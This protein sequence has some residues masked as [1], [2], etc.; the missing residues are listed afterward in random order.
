MSSPRHHSGWLRLGSVRHFA[1]YEL[2]PTRG[3]NWKDE[4]T[5][6]VST[7]KRKLVLKTPDWSAI[8][9]A[10]PHAKTFPMDGEL[11][12]AV[13][14]GV[15]ETIVLR[16]MGYDDAPA[17]IMS[18]YNW[19]ARFKPMDLQKATAAFLTVYKR[20]LV[21]NEP[22]TGKSISSLWAADFLLQE[23]VVKKVL[24]ACPLSTTQVVWG[25]EIRHHLSHRSFEVLTGSKEQRLKRLATPGLQYAV[26][27]HD[28]FNIMK[29]HLDEFDLVI[30]DEATAL[31]TPG[32]Q[33]FRQFYQ[34]VQKNDVWLW[35]LTGT[36]ISQSPVDAWT[37]ARLVQNPNVPKSYTAFRDLV[38]DKITTFKYVPRPNAIQVCKQVLQPSIRFALDEFKELP[39]SVFLEHECPMTPEQIKLFR[40]M[41]ERA[42][43]MA[44]DVAAPNMA[45]VL[46]KLIQICCGVVYATDG[47]RIDID[48]TGRYEVLKEICNELGAH[49]VLSDGQTEGKVIVFV[50][51]RGVQDRL[52]EMM[53]KDGY[54]VVSVHGDVS[55]GERNKIFDAFQNSRQ[56][57]ILLAH[58]KVAAHGLTLTRAKDIIWY[59]PIYSLESYEQANA[60]IRRL[61]TDG[62]TRIHHLFGTSFEKEL[63]RRLQQKKR[64]LAE[65]LELVNGT[66][67]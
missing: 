31:K 58:P 26:I 41:K 64:V 60:R 45:V 35:L 16:N 50:P 49:D 59:A 9:A 14:H 46:M 25:K 20:A 4:K 22:G 42:V 51:L 28:G 23:G 6:L 21:L 61:T 39:Q 15:E 10:I 47:D 44:H 5:M 52:Q 33:R 63:Y 54:D 48:A 2:P 37:L 57:R 27:N 43:L 67:E 40:E 29:D 53:E 55:Q 65:F 18:Y 1:K 19:P 17:P 11:L 36:P 62:K 7:T 38:M 32:S 66:N 12:T 13:H 8:L 34:W 30:Y 3:V 56:Y 24:V